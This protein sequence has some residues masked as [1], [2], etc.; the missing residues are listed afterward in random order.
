MR[1]PRGSRGRDPCEYGQK[2]RNV[3]RGKGRTSHQSHRLHRWAH[4]PSGCRHLRMMLVWFVGWIGREQKRTQHDEPLGLLDSV[5]VGLGVTE[6]LPL[7]VLGLLDLF[8]GTVSDEDGLSSPLDDNVLALGDGGEIDLNLGL[9]Q[10]ICGSR[11][12][13]EEVCSAC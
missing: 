8:G 10:D 5:R 9:S 12:V 6:R 13:D 11:H 4:N 7:G 1:E 3:N 2:C